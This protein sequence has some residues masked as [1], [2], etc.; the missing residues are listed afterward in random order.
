M[1]RFSLALIIGL[2]LMIPSAFAQGPAYGYMQAATGSQAIRLEEVKLSGTLNQDI[3]KPL[4]LKADG[5]EYIIRL[6]LTALAGLKI[7]QGE[8]ISIEGYV[9]DAVSGTP[10]EGSKV[11]IV[12]KAT[13]QGKEYIFAAN[14]RQT[15]MGGMHGNRRP[16]TQ[17]WQGHGRFGANPQSQF[18]PGGRW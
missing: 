4:T 2:V 1:K 18:G 12:N 5:K 8:K 14:Q 10:F 16:G 13:I 9:L 17:S 3:G 15:M 7:S 6:P 11:V